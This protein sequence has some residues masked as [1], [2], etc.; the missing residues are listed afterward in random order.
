MLHRNSF[1]IRKINRWIKQ[2]GLE[3]P[4]LQHLKRIRN[5]S[6]TGSWLLLSGRSE[7]PTIPQELNLPESFLVDVP[8]FPARTMEHLTL[9]NQ[10]WP[11]VY[12]PRRKNQPD[13][14]SR[15]K[16]AWAWDA[17]NVL[18]TEARKAKEAGEVSNSFLIP[19]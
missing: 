14:W 17:I 12:A 19:I 13:P 11:T 18:L 6:E 4:D 8:M 15:A 10:I 9:K 3:T 2:A 1:F 5:S 7:P 16:V